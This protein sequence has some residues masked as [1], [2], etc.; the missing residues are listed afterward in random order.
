MDQEKLLQSIEK[1]KNTIQWLYGTLES[2]TTELEKIEKETYRKQ[3][4][5]SKYIKD[6]K[7]TYR[8]HLNDHTPSS[9]DFIKQKLE[10]EE[11]SYQKHFLGSLSSRK[12]QC[13]EKQ[14]ILSAQIN[15][16]EEDLVAL[17]HQLRDFLTI[18]KNCSRNEKTLDEIDTLLQRSLQTS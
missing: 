6:L 1:K 3:E 5:K 9:K 8:Q 12:T 17:Q 2:I 15:G 13:K 4:V 18:C 14:G 7:E 16:E 11:N 10:E